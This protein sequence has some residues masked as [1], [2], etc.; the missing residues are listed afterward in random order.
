[1]AVLTA[2]FIEILSASRFAAGGGP[3]GTVTDW[4]HWDDDFEVYHWHHNGGDHPEPEPLFVESGSWDNQ[5]NWHESLQ[6]NRGWDHIIPDD[7]QAHQGC[8]MN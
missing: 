8:N 5:T 1:M 6:W 4:K 7:E 3:C 2:G